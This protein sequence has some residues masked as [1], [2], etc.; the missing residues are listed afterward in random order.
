MSGKSDEADERAR[1]AF[2][3]ARDELSPDDSS[4]RIGLNEVAWSLWQQGSY[5]AAEALALKA[6]AGYRRARAIPNQS[7]VNAIDTLACAQRDLGQLDEALA[8]FEEI[9]S[10]YRDDPESV[11]GR[12]N[13][14]IILHHAEC[15]TKLRRYEDAET[16][17]LAIEDR[18]ADV[19]RALVEL[20]EAW[21]KPDE[22]AEWRAK[23]P[24]PADDAAPDS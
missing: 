15:L 21:D 4:E 16:M 18:T 14:E 9:E 17:L 8:L 20:Y 12:P 1:Q 10:A 2:R 13:P 6:V 5:E 7:M 23:L 22:A 3:I 19:I 11:L 24:E